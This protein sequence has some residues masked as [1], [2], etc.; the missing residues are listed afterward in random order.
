MCVGLYLV[1]R[2]EKLLVTFGFWKIGKLN[3]FQLNRNFIFMVQIPNGVFDVNHQ[4]NNFLTVSTYSEVCV[5]C[6]ILVDNPYFFN[7]ADSARGVYCT[8]FEPC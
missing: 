1:Y 6:L 7:S 2:I 5:H 3:F 8:L 4:H